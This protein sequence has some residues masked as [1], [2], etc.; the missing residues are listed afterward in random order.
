MLDRDSSDGEV[1][2]VSKDEYIYETVDDVEVPSS[3]DENAIPAADN[4]DS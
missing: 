1:N 2:D 3:D 4:I